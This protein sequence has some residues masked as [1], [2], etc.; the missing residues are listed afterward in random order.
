MSQKVQS[1]QKLDVKDDTTLSDTTRP[2][3]LI[4]E[5]VNFIDHLHFDCCEW[6]CR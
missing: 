4:L 3:I 6:L 5:Y 2:S 1:D